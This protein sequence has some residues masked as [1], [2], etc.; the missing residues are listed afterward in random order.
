MME[1]P[2]SDKHYL[3]YKIM[4][5]KSFITLGPEL[6]IDQPGSHLPSGTAFKTIEQHIFKM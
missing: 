1:W 4:A 3:S 6:G 2:A 5:V